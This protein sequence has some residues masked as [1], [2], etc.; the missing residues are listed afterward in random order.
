MVLEDLFPLTVHRLQDETL[1]LWEESPDGDVTPSQSSLV[2]GDA[3]EEGWIAGLSSSWCKLL[4]AA[5]DLSLRSV[6][7]L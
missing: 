4:G 1:L 6:G 2:P 3:V 7:H 5:E